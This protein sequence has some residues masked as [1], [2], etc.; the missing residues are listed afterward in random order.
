MSVLRGAWSTSARPPSSGVIWT[1]PSF[2]QG[3]WSTAASCTTSLDY[4]L[5][6][7]GD[8]PKELLAILVE[9]PHRRGP[10]DAKG[11]GAAG[12]LTIA[13]ATA[14]A[15]GVRLRSLPMTPE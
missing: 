5:T 4:Q 6:A 9:V 8:L 13:L 12:I 14:N 7:L 3:S 15:T 11:V 10:F 1:T 2:D